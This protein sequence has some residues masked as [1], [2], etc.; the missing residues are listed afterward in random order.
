MRKLMWDNG[1]FV[2]ITNFFTLFSGL[3]VLLY[4]TPPS[5]VG[6]TQDGPAGHMNYDEARTYAPSKGVS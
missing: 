4:F 6:L 3:R 1:H 5:Q 2:T